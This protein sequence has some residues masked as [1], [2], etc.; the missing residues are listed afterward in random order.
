M[1]A[2]VNGALLLGLLLALAST[3]A[4]DVGFLMQH[5]AASRMPSLELRHPLSS[6][7]SLLGARRWTVGFVI[8]LAGWGL[9]LVALGHAPL[10][11][12]QAVAAAGIGLLVLL[13]AA[14]RRRAPARKQTVGAIIATVGLAAL[15]LS[16]AGQAAP[17]AHAV[18][19]GGVV[20]CAVLVAVAT[21]LLARRGTAASGGAG[22]GLCYGFGDVASKALLVALPVHPGLGSVVSQ[23][24]LYLAL[25]GHGVG[26]LV[27]QRSF[28]RGGAVAAVAPMSAALNILPMLAGVV[29]LRDPLPASPALLGLR[30]AAFAAAVSGAYLLAGSHDQGEP[31]PEHAPGAGTPALTPDLA[32][33]RP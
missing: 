13:A 7:R 21:W 16:L 23:P 15:G 32:G 17:H 4:L 12:V 1:D 18:P 24:Y 20:A 19:A 5:H 8:G 6:V 10:S 33:A 28:Q 11:L 2:I 27:L 22:A 31:S 9:Y 14:A 3:V 26:F 29:V 25:A 30:L